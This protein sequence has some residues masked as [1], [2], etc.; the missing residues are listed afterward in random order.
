MIFYRNGS[1]CLKISSQEVYI[2][3]KSMIDNNAS[4]KIQT[5]LKDS[6][7]HPGVNVTFFRDRDAVEMNRGKT[8]ISM[9][10]FIMSYH[11]LEAYV[12]RII[13]ERKGTDLIFK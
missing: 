3:D 13:W 11:K 5:G 6:V 1:P 2:D 9:A 4:I 8:G 7:F 12:D 10:P